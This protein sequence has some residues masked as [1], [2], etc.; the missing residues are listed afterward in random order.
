MVN[1]QAE[2]ELPRHCDLELPLFAGSAWTE[3]VTGAAVLATSAQQILVTYRVLC[4]DTSDLHPAGSPPYT[5]WPFADVNYD[6]YATPVFCRGNGSQSVDVCDY[7]QYQAWPGPKWPNDVVGGP[8]TVPRSVGDVRP[9]GPRDTGADGHL[10]IFDEA[11]HTEYDLWQATTVRNGPCAS[12]GGGRTGSAIL[13][14]GAADYFDVDGS[15]SNP[16]GLSSA[17]AMG[18]PMLAG[19]IVPEDIEA[20]AIQHALAVGIPGPRNLSP[21]PEDPLPSD[22]F[23]PASTT[24]TD[25]YSDNSSAMAAGQRL[26]MKGS[27]VDEDGTAIAEGDLALITRMFIAAL[28]TYGAYVVDNTSGFTYYAEDIHTAVLELSDD[29]INDLIGRPHGTTLPSTK[30]RW[31]LVIE[32]L[33][34][35]LETIPFAYGLCDEASSSV[36]TSNFV[37]VEPASPPVH[38]FADPF[39]SGDTWFWS[40]TTGGTTQTVGVLRRKLR[41][42]AYAKRCH[43][44][45]SEGPLVE[46]LS[47]TIS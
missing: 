32:T 15:G 29:D 30:T 24:E 17:R 46:H 11:T 20:G 31:Q 21:N 6:H 26:R 44:E 27:L 18:T 9:A 35:D 16:D 10:V 38:I 7:D 19:L 39:E 23:Y 14:T 42:I 37:V 8:I 13:E 4:G 28:R 1:A 36:T 43:P 2:V 33:N 47:D 3:G 22:W 40:S 41:P 12:L 45:C 5:D 34:A 25:F